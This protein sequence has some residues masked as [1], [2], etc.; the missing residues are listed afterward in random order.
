MLPN[1]DL[2]QLTSYYSGLTIVNSGSVDIDITSSFVTGITPY[3]LG[4]VDPSSHFVY[5]FSTPHRDDLTDGYHTL[6]IRHQTSVLNAGVPTTVDII[7]SYKV[8]SSNQLV[9]VQENGGIAPG[10]YSLDAGPLLIR[11]VYYVIETFAES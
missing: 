6:P 5:M 1:P 4:S 11:V 9:L 3:D 10:T 7:L 2:I 8:D